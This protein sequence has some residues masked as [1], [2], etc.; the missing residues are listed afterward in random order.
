MQ[1]LGRPGAVGTEVLGISGQERQFW[2]LNQDELIQRII[3][4]QEC[5]VK[6][7]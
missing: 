5:D 3:I 2:N 7:N 4:N 6:P 1:I